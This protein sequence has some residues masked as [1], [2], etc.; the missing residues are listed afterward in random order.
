VEQLRRADEVWLQERDWVRRQLERLAES[1]AE[2]TEASESLGPAL[3]ELRAR[4]DVL[5]AERSPVAE[6][7]DELAAAS[8]RSQETLEEVRARL[9]ELAAAVAEAGSRDWLSGQEA[10]GLAT[11]IEDAERRGTIVASELA[12]STALW[13]SELAA[14]G[15]R[16]DRVDAGAREETAARL[17][18][19]DRLVGG[20][21]ARLEAL[22]RDRSPTTLDD[23]VPLRVE[24][25]AA[26]LSRVESAAQSAA[27]AAAVAAAASPDEELE[28]IRALLDGVL[29]RVAATEQSVTSVSSD[30]TSLKPVLEALAKRIEVAE[31]TAMQVPAGASDGADQGDGRFRLELRAFGLRMEHAEAAARENRE[32]VLTQ[33]ERLASRVEWRLQRLEE[34]AQ[35]AS[36]AEPEEAG[37]Q[38]VPIRGGADTS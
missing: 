20:L 27:A 30:A 33:L 25:L 32:A 3:E 13:A 10:S 4:L 34:A 11:R 23:D 21:S 6:R 35:A 9:D 5:D 38:V 31:R 7:I 24:E 2:T 15:E 29:T 17:D 18:L 1:Q 28:E 16:L 12:Q 8:T 14:L 22:E 19:T 36:F 37:A 26:R